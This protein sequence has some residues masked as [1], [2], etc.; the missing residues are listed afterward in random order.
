M[1]RIQQQEAYL[2][3]ELDAERTRV[4]RLEAENAQ[5][6]AHLQSLHIGSRPAASS[7]GNSKFEAEHIA[8]NAVE[9]T[10]SVESDFAQ[11]STIPIKNASAGSKPGK[12]TRSRSHSRHS[13][14]FH[15][16]S[17]YPITHQTSTGPMIAWRARRRVLET[18]MEQEQ[19]RMF[20]QGRRLSGS[21]SPGGPFVASTGVPG[22]VS[23]RWA[24]S[25][26]SSVSS[27]GNGS[28]ASDVNSLRLRLADCEREL[29]SCYS[30]SQIYKKELVALRQ[31][32]GMSV[33]DLYLDDPVPMALKSTYAEG[34]SARPR[35]SQSVSSSS[36]TGTTPQL[37]RRG[38]GH[39]MGEYFGML[40]SVPRRAAQR[41]RSV[42]LS[43][44]RSMEDHQSAAAT[45]SAADQASLFA[46]KS[47]TTHRATRN[48]K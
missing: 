2:A 41:P 23:P 37:A 46:F 28:V 24:H 45:F 5:L 14:K 30:Q 38:S 11:T 15:T 16:L 19:E 17:G 39:H 34:G 20:N 13:G 43:P 36:S 22:A 42:L 7:A 8:N 6:L 10:S 27:F 29:V 25:R 9:R 3:R 32:L 33:D 44:R 4:K 31:R 18:A 35:R 21:I 12:G 1:S 40:P 47:G 48:I 26:S